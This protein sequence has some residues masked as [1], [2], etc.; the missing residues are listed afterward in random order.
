MRKFLYLMLLLSGLSAACST[1]PQPTGALTRDQAR[2]LLRETAKNT[3]EPT[4]L[5]DLFAPTYKQELAEKYGENWQQTFI[6]KERSNLTFCLS[7]LT[8][9]KEE[10]TGNQTKLTGRYECF[11]VFIEL[12]G[13]YYLAQFGQVVNGM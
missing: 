5:F 7:C 10:T 6:T 1:I 2:Q 12:D 4:P 9:A 11:A 8:D 13:R 3:D